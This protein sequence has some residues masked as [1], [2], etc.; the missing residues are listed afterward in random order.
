MAVSFTPQSDGGNFDPRNVNAVW[1]T[2]ASGKLVR[3]LYARAGQ[4]AGY[5]SQWRRV[6]TASPQTGV[7]GV[8][9]AT[10]SSFSAYSGTWDLTNAKTSAKVAQ[11][12]YT[13]NLQF[14]DNDAAGPFA[15]VKFV[16]QG[17]SFDTTVPNATFPYHKN[18]HLKYTP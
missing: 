13:L 11:G 10:A 4:R 18:I 15:S 1:I 12:T 17:T 16:L 14:A 8:A 7:D 5:L 2:D 9:G 3:N 6:Y